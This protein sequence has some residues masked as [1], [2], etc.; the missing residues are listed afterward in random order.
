MKKTRSRKSRDT[1]PLNPVTNKS[2]G[3]L[4]LANTRKINFIG[5]SVTWDDTGGRPIPGGHA[6]AVGAAALTGQLTQ[7]PR[8]VVRPRV[9]RGQETLKKE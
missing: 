9:R 2:R 6:G 7:V 3:F 4:I 5:R 1:V 8:R